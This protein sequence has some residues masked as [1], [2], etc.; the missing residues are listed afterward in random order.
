MGIEQRP[1]LFRWQ[2]ASTVAAL[3]NSI[4]LLSSSSWDTENRTWNTPLPGQ[5]DGKR[6]ERNRQEEMDTKRKR[7]K[8]SFSIY[9]GTLT[10]ILY[11]GSVRLIQFVRFTCLTLIQTQMFVFRWTRFFLNF[12]INRQTLSAAQT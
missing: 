6:S 7:K 4:S 8:T 11:A 2:T 1:Q 9:F 12:P 5:T 10:S 3:P